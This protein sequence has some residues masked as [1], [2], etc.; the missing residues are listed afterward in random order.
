MLMPDEIKAEPPPNNSG[1][2]EARLPE[3]NKSSDEPT[4]ARTLEGYRLD[5]LDAIH[6][7]QSSKVVNDSGLFKV[8]Y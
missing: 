5:I 1:S 6:S 4:P 8:D 3:S 2:E 7:G